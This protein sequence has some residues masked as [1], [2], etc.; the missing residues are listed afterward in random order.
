MA[1]ACVD[2]RNIMV[3]FNLAFISDVALVGLQG[4]RAPSSGER[5]PSSGGELLPTTAKRRSE[6]SPSSG[7]LIAPSSSL[8]ASAWSSVGSVSTASTIV[9]LF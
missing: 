9:W 6:R 8:S 3:F 5:A 7:S 2:A 1:K 4:E